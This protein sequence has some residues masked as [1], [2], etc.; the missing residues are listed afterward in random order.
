MIPYVGKK[1]EV[2][3]NTRCWQNTVCFA[4]L[5]SGGTIQ[6]VLLSIKKEWQHHTARRQ[7]AWLS[8]PLWIRPVT[9]SGNVQVIFLSAKCKWFC[10]KIQA[11]LAVSSQLEGSQHDCHRHF[12][13]DLLLSTAHYTTRSPS[14]ATSGL[15]LLSI[16]IHFLFLVDWT[17]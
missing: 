17:K 4:K 9:N 8:T 11:I 5:K 16:F 7:P 14:L 6:V 2:L 15:S 10:Y 13:S 3:L 1:Q 12:G